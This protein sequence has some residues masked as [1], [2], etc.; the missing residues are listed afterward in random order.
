[1]QVGAFDLAPIPT[2][3]QEDVISLFS[4]TYDN[5]MVDSFNPY[6]TDS[7]TQGEQ[8]TIGEENIISYTNLLYVAVVTT[9]NTIDATDMTHIHLDLLTED[10]P[11]DFIIK[12]KDFGADNADGGGDDTEIAY[13]VPSSQIVSGQWVSLDIPLTSFI[14]LNNKANLGFIIFQSAGIDNVFIDNLYYHK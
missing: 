13:T 1:M 14:G 7:E 8:T 10:A 3:P 2:L 12:I 5:V 11:A 4:D 9:T 6:W